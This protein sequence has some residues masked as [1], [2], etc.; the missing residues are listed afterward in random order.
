M[1]NKWDYVVSSAAWCWLLL[2]FFFGLESTGSRSSLNRRLIVYDPSRLLIIIIISTICPIHHL[3]F[4]SPKH[5]THE[6]APPTSSH[7]NF[8]FNISNMNLQLT[9]STLQLT[10]E[11]NYTFGPAMSRTHTTCTHG[12][13]KLIM[14]ELANETG[15]AVKNVW[16]VSCEDSCWAEEKLEMF[17]GGLNSLEDPMLFV[18]T[19]EERGKMGEGKISENNLL[20][21]SHLLPRW[22]QRNVSLCYRHHH[23]CCLPRNFINYSTSFLERWKHFPC[24]ND[25]VVEWEEKKKLFSTFHGATHLCQ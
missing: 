3:F 20:C 19:G 24:W 14:N 21:Y 11:I 8:S 2:L 13:W 25:N 9:R 6:T 23:R 4:L 7:I 12:K 18:F 1:K 16:N 5:N 10:A 15:E 17:C 22:E